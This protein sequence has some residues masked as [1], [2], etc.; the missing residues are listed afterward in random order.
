MPSNELKGVAAGAS[1][2]EMTW[3]TQD[4]S[5]A[6]I[7]AA[8]SG[9]AVSSIREPQSASCPAASA[10]DSCVLTG[11]GTPPAALIAWQ[12][13]TY[14]AASDTYTPTT[15]RGRSPRQARPAAARL[16][17]AASSANEYGSAACPGTSAARWPYLAA[18]STSRCVAVISPFR[19][20]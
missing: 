18:V 16:I 19:L 15:S 10:I 7:P 5:A 12:A 4:W 2:N 8:A 11:H 13:S 1:P 3:R 20:K 9:G 6:A 17:V 14:A